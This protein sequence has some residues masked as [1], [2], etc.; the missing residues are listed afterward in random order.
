MLR[1]KKEKRVWLVMTGRA[2]V[3][4]RKVLNQG[5]T[6]NQKWRNERVDFV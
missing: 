1:V 3:K 2:D 5:K 4:A 6:E